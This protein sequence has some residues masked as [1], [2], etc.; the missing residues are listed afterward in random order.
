MKNQLIIFAILL[1]TGACQPAAKSP[2]NNDHLQEDWIQL[3]NGKDLSGWDIKI[4]GYPI[5][6]NYNKTFAVVDSM[7][8]IQYDQYESFDDAFGHMYYQTPYS[9]YKLRFDY[10]FVGEQLK[11]GAT[12]NVRNSGIMLHSQSAQSNEM[13]KVFRSPLRCSY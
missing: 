11:G 13:G 4:A 2:S 8:R 10:R 6:E 3:F 7:I 9:Y 1:L 12:W 5:N